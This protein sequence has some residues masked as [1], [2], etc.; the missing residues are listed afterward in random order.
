MPSQIRINH[1]TRKVLQ[2]AADNVFWVFL[3]LMIIL[4]SAISTPWVNVGLTAR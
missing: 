4:G 1:R 2:I 3:A